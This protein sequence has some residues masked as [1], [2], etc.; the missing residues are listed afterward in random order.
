MCVCVCVCVCVHPHH[1]LVF[2]VRPLL[3]GLTEARHAGH[4]RGD[5]DVRAQRFNA[6]QCVRFG[7]GVTAGVIQR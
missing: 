5:V 3:T 2:G 4:R 6:E 1:V 7:E